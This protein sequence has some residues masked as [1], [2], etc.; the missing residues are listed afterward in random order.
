M[1]VL[2]VEPQKV[3]YR[4]EIEHSLEQMQALVGGCIESLYPFG[5]AVAL[6]CNDEGKL[7]GLPA[8]RGLRNEAGHIY[9]VVCGTFFLCG[10]PTDSDRLE[11]LSE[12][13]MAHYE[14]YFARPEL[15]FD[16]GGEIICIPWDVRP[17]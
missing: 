5:K 15:F 17:L 1:L 7:M 8:N 12:E 13:Q 2:V 16:L 10:A 4:L 14:R 11:S 6:V 3:P 9:D